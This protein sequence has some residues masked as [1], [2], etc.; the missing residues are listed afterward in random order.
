MDAD[1]L[2]LISVGF[3]AQLVDGALGMAFGVITTSVMLTMGLPPAQASALVHTAECF[4]TGA[5]GAWH[6]FHNNVDWRLTARLGLAGIAGAV[7]GAVI[8]SNIGTG[9]VRPLVAVYLMAMGIYI[10]FNAFRLTARPAPAAPGAW[11]IPVG[12]A[13]GFLDA[14][15]GGWGP[16][17]TS[18]LVGA[19]HSP[20]MVIGS[21]NTAE[22]F[23]TVAAATTF[24]FEL[25][26]SLWQHIVPLVLG[27]LFAAPF[28]GWVAKRVPARGLM[29]AVG[30]LIVVLSLLQVA[31]ML[32]VF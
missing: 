32:P 7:L 21:V 17:A 12:F 29:V 16:V 25:G 26:A 23:V 6:I 31:R 18:S 20:R 8:L 14:G 15:G 3:F 13:A 22:F 24:F 9:F 5:S 10:L 1:L 30:A 4:T 28:G 19:G 27:G 2:I 11:S